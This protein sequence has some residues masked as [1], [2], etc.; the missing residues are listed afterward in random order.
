MRKMQKRSKNW[1]GVQCP[2]KIKIYQNFKPRLSTFKRQNLKNYYLVYIFW[3][4][5]LDVIKKKC[6]ESHCNTPNKIAFSFIFPN[7]GRVK[8]KL[9]IILFTVGMCLLIAVTNGQN[10]LEAD[11]ASQCNGPY[12]SDL[13]NVVKMAAY[14]QCRGSCYDE[15]IC[16]KLLPS[17]CRPKPC[18]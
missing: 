1:P 18:K 10:D 11:E 4:K 16:C 17:G 9:E 5:F 2:L 15:D 8:M 3:I 7:I 12:S 13:D 14:T 6:D